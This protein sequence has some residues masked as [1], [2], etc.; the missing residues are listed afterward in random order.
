MGRPSEPSPRSMQSP[1]R[2]PPPMSQPEVVDGSQS[3]FPAGSDIILTDRLDLSFIKDMTSVL[4][5]AARARSEDALGFDTAFGITR[6]DSEQRRTYHY[7]ID[8]SVKF[9]IDLGAIERFHQAQPNFL[10]Q[11]RHI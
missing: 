1:P 11:R 4:P 2:D 8:Y 3:P 5:A 9:D 6:N 7:D 10:I